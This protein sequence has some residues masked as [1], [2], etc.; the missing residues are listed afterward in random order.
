[1]K[2]EIVGIDFSGDLSVCCHPEILL[3]WQRDVT[4]S[5]LYKGSTIERTAEE[6]NN[7]F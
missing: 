3:S 5:P 4:T 7:F 2:F 6:D 1:M